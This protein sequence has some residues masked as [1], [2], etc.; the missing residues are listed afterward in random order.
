MTGPVTALLASMRRLG[1]SFL[2]AREV[3]DDFGNSWSFLLDS[4][5]AVAAAVRQSVRRW[6][7]GKL[8]HAIPGLVPGHCDVGA[9]SCPEGT[10]LVDFAA[11]IAQ[12]LRSR[13]SGHDQNDWK[14]NWRGDLAFA[15][16]GGQLPQARRA[17][18]P[19]WGIEDA[20]CQLC[21]KQTGTLEHRFSC[22]ATCPEEGWPAA[23]TRANVVLDRLSS[24]RRRLL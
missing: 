14:P 20:N 8:A 7:L 12:L 2:S 10:L 19:S 17:A 16:S 5:A 3:I 18:V 23:P 6:R 11:P 4:P 9:P 24:S 21:H 15:V 13:G 1:W 22:T